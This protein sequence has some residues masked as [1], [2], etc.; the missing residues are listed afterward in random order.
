MV[1]AVLSLMVMAEMGLDDVEM[2]AG[3]NEWSPS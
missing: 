2:L 1:W 3:G